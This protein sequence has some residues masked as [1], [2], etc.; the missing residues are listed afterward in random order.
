MRRFWQWAEKEGAP[1]IELESKWRESHCWRECLR[2]ATT[3]WQRSPILTTMPI[4]TRRLRPHFSATERDAIEDISQSNQYKIL[5]M[6]GSFAC[7]GQWSDDLDRACYRA[8]RQFHVD[9][10]IDEMDVIEELHSRITTGRDEEEIN[11]VLATWFELQSYRESYMSRNGQPHESSHVLSEDKVRSIREDVYWYTPQLII[12]KS[13]KFSEGSKF[14]EDFRR[15]RVSKTLD[16]LRS[17]FL[18]SVFPARNIFRQ[19]FLEP[20][21]EILPR[22]NSSWKNP[23]ARDSRWWWVRQSRK[24]RSQIEGKRQEG[25]TGRIGSSGIRR[26]SLPL[27]KTWKKELKP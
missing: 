12:K 27:F 20:L 19:N 10:S 4:S 21:Q 14:L 5:R 8:A 9:L 26:K 13:P 18:R 2:W 6:I 11:A 22:I 15:S 23:R 1:N 16:F 25:K 24:S 3:I 17:L 7:A